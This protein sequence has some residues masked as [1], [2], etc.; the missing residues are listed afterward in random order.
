ML[1][2]P[3]EVGLELVSYLTVPQTPQTGA[4]FVTLPCETT[5]ARLE[6]DCTLFLVRDGW[7]CIVE[8]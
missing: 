6:V 1:H 8:Q 5:G 3:E 4:S 2:L 7:W